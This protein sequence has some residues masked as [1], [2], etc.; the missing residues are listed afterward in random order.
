MGQIFRDQG[1]VEPDN[2]VGLDGDPD[3]V[4]GSGHLDR[5]RL[6]E[7]PEAVLDA[8]AFDL[9]GAIAPFPETGNRAGP[10]LALLRSGGDRAGGRLG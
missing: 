2:P 3:P 9:R 5:A 1:G 6:L 10:F 7:D 8:L 4:M